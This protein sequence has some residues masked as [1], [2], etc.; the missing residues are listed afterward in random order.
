MLDEMRPMLQFGKARSQSRVLL[1]T[2]SGLKVHGR[3]PF[4]PSFARTGASV[5]NAGCSKPQVILPTPV[6]PLRNSVLTIAVQQSANRG[7]ER[8]HSDRLVEIGGRSLL[9]RL[10]LGL[11]IPKGGHQDDGRMRGPGFELGHQLHAPEGHPKIGDDDRGRKM[12][13][14]PERLSSIGRLYDV[15]SLIPKLIGDEAPHGGIVIGQQ[16]AFLIAHDTPF[17]APNSWKLDR[18]VEKDVTRL[19]QG[20][21]L[22]LPTSS[23]VKTYLHS[24]S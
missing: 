9:V 7:L 20:T 21:G 19:K 16:D 24:K 14:R 12:N 18:I 4:K 11:G 8:L 22:T 5:K 6:I 1:V 17:P 15:V 10:R 13:Q 3:A 23:S 2:P